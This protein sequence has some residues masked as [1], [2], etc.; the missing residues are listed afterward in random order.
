MSDLI[1][2]SKITKPLTTLKGVYLK[3][4]NDGLNNFI[5]DLDNK[6]ISYQDAL[7]NFKLFID[8][9]IENIDKQ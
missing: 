9:F 6:D 8:E 5:K 7:I 2:F 3:K 4:Y 1:F